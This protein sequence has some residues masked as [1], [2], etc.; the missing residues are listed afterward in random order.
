MKPNTWR[1]LLIISFLTGLSGLL[2]LSSTLVSIAHSRHH[3]RIVLTDA[4]LTVIAGVSLIYLAALLRKGKYNAW[5]IAMPVYTF[6]IVRN[7]EHFVIQFHNENRLLPSI[8]NLSLPILG[9]ILLIVFRNSFK[10]RSEILSFALALRRSAIILLVAFFY[11]I[12][13]FY[14]LDE[15]D[16][17]QE[18]SLTSSAHY[19]VDQI[20]LTTN[21]VITPYSRRAT[22]FLDSLGVLSASAIIYTAVS[23]FAPIRFRLRHSHQ[24][25]LDFESLVK[26]YA[27]TSE[28]FFK[29]WPADKSY[30]FNSDRTAAIAYKSTAGTAL[31]VGDP[32]GP[33]SEFDSLIEQF[34]NF[35]WINDWTP[36]FIHSSETN[37]SIYTKLGF[38][39]QKIGEEALVN[40]TN[41]TDRVNG[42]KYFRHINNKFTKLGYGC[43]ELMPPHNQAT[44]NQLKAISKDWLSVPG[45]AERGFML[46]Y[47]SEAYMQRCRIIVAKDQTGQIE[48]FIN[49][50]PTIKPNEANFDFLRHMANSPG[51]INDYLMSF[52]ITRLQTDDIEFLNMGLAP[53]SG[54]DEADPAQSNLITG[55]LSFTYTNG[56][57]F[58]SF[59]GLKRFKAK[60]EPQWQSRYIVY[61]GGLGGFTKTINALMRAM[62][63]K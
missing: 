7:Y 25:L 52:F 1:Q 49:Q 2:T 18:L 30:F 33:I 46:G 15:K 9:L 40:T 57:R 44:I 34:S 56:S 17:H 42:N 26:K 24:D 60:Y 48:A 4:H 21:R 12:A 31:V 14:L 10:V 16:F 32:L 51:N 43:E 19:T 58:Y 54:L 47:F 37:L 28:D 53:L 38:E 20:G 27:Q 61:R 50:V 5:L 36:A 62:R 35:C 11:G 22:L 55:L 6:L 59:Q 63:I 29:L 41:F 23:L 13:G 45:R 8:L 3:V 39:Y